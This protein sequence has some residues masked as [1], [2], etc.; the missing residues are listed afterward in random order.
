MNVAVS[1]WGN[2]LGIRVPSAVVESMGIAAG[3]TLSYSV[4]DGTLV[5]QKELST[6]QLFED[7]YGKPFDEITTED[8]GPGGE[9]DWGDDVGG[10]AI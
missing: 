10:E 9:L 6:R 3:D 8:I 2:S 1:K 7:F 5:L 4:K